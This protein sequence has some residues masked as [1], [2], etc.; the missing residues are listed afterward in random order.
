MKENA[1][2]ALTRATAVAT[3]VKELVRF[4]FAIEDCYTLA[5]LESF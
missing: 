1:A 3:C 2:Q 4:K 5:K